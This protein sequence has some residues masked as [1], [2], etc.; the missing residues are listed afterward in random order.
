MRSFTQSS[1]GIPI[2]DGGPYP[3]L[4]PI[5]HNLA[6]VVSPTRPLVPTRHPPFI[7][8]NPLPLPIPSRH[9][10]FDIASD[11]SIVSTRAK[12]TVNRAI[13]GSWADSTMKR[14]SGSIKQ[15]IRFC[16]AE[17]VAEHLRFP[18]DEFVL[19]S[20]AASSL[21]IHTGSTARARIS[22][23]KA[24]HITHNLE[25]KGSLRLQHVLSG[26]HNL[27]PSS[28]RRTPRPP[29]NARMLEQL[30]E[31]LDLQSPIDVAIAA[32]ATTAFWGQCRLGELLSTSASSLL[33]S[34]LPTRADFKRSLRNP[35]SCIL[36]LP[37]TKTHSHG[38]DV[39]LVDQRA[40]INPISLLKRHFRINNLPN[41]THLFAYCTTDR[42]VPLTKSVFL[43]RC[44]D[45]W[46]RLGYPRTTG[47]CFRIG[48]TTELLIAGTPPDIVKATGRWSSES[49]LRYWRSLD[50]IAPQHIR[51]LHKFTHRR[52][53]RGATTV[54]G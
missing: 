12:D 4:V 43:R 39:V 40:P 18:A 11:S 31:N 15:F 45:I 20:F 47:H 1:A 36:H 27:A 3:T 14:Y 53:R 29:I 24:W 23:L 44:N 22:A 6:T 26:V 2:S 13:Q 33:D 28:S 49:F 51:N 5:S 37:R 25:W 41:D 32:C 9:L 10:F 46:Q 8:Q 34:P 21:G 54:V 35:H 16:D 42:S 17:R 30:I 19:C 48:G 52:K 50:D 7:T 38:Q